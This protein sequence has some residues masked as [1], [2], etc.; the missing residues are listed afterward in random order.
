VPLWCTSG[1]DDELL[2]V[3]AREVVTG[4]GR[5]IQGVLLD[6]EK[7]KA[8]ASEEVAELFPRALLRPLTDASPIDPDRTLAVLPAVLDPG[9]RAPPASPGFFTVVR[10]G[11]GVTW[12]AF[13][14]GAVVVGAGLRGLLALNRR[15]L[16]FV[17]AVTHE[18]RTPLTTF[19]MYSEMLRDGMVP[20]GKEK[21]Y[22]SVLHDESLRL[23]HLVQN[24]LDYSRLETRREEAKE[25]TGSLGALLEPAV[26]RLGERCD[27]AGRAFRVA[28]GADSQLEISLDTAALE[29]ILLNLVDNACKYGEGE[30]ELSVEADGGTLC[31]RVRDHG[32]GIPAPD[33]ERIFSAFHR[34]PGAEGKGPGVG[35]GLSLCRQ[36]ARGMGGDLKLVPGE[37]CCF[38]LTL[39]L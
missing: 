8:V 11:L 25:Q 20:A 39:P 29:Q 22:F 15:R 31:F 37:G 18:L 27:R 6:W 26:R 4:E 32:P 24:V 23:A 28:A 17:S 2:L 36:W 3:L 13:L 33:A 19:R 16:D 35:L 14:I 1:D 7:L 5:T 30:V 21:E 9:P 12:A 10:V 38:A 34:G